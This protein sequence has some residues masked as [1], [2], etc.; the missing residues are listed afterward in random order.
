MVEAIHVPMRVLRL[1]EI[2]RDVFR[3]SL[4]PSNDGFPCYE[5]GQYLKLRMPDGEMKPY[6]IASAPESRKIELQIMAPRRIGSRRPS[7]DFLSSAKF[8]HCRMPFGRCRLPDDDRPILMIAGGTGISQMKAMIDSSIARNEDREIWLY[9]GGKT[10]ESLYLDDEFSEISIEHPRIRYR[11]VVE[12]RSLGARF[13]AGYPHIV[14]LKDHVD[15]RRF[16]VY[17]SGPPAMASAVCNSMFVNGVPKDSIHCDW[18][19]I[20]GERRLA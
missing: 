18:L 19:D 9:W 7:V 10:P 8:V 13:A 3:V 11:P 16:D 6:S 1:E 4:R 14:A 5:A 17:C 15:M 12:V 2:G 20:A